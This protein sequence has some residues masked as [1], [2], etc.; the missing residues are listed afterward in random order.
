MSSVH[1]TPWESS[2]F[3]F[4]FID[5]QGSNH[6]NHGL[7]KLLNQMSNKM[8]KASTRKEPAMVSREHSPA[9]DDSCQL[10]QDLTFRAPVLRLQETMMS[11]ISHVPNGSMMFSISIRHEWVFLLD[12]DVAFPNH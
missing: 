2:L 5:L 7:T 8:K 10:V 9:S 12:F 3:Y 11:L 6:R 4:D 1:I